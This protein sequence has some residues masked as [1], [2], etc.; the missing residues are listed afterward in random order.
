MTHPP[1]LDEQLT[2]Q[3]LLLDDLLTHFF[4]LPFNPLP[5]CIR[6]SI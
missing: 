4:V 2:L 1:V 5:G 6:K 3:N